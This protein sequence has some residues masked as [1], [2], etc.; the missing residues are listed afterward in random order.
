MGQK[1]FGK[2]KILCQKKFRVQKISG[3]KKCGSKINVGFQKFLFPKK[4]WVQSNFGPKNFGS[5]EFFFWFKKVLSTKTVGPKKFPDTFQTAS[6]HL[7]DTF[8]TTSR[9]RPLNFQTP[10]N[11]LKSPKRLWWWGGGGGGMEWSG[12]GQF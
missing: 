4:S 3:A 5:K 2:E 10:S 7:L 8:P 6:Q 9:H 11:A 12:L 1:I